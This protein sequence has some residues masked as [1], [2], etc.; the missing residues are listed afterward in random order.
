MDTN[1]HTL[2]TLFEQLGLDS[3]EPAVRRFVAAHR[4]LDSALALDQAPIWN[5]SQ[6]AFIREAL[7]QDSDWAEAVDELSALLR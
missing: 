1:P 4:P 6:A 5:A 3:S 7:E 2:E